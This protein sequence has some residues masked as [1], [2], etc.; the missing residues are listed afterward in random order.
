MPKQARR[1]V[2]KSGPAEGRASA[3]GEHERGYSPSR[4]GVRGISPEKIF[5]LRLPLC[6]FL[7]H[8]GSV[9]SRLGLICNRRHWDIH[10]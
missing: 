3:R 8:F 5:D 4:K 7:M 6:A 10:N 2:V 9:F 1:H